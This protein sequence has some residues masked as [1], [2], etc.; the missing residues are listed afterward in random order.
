[1]IVDGTD[2]PISPYNGSEVSIFGFQNKG[3]PKA[4]KAFA[5]YSRAARTELGRTALPD[6]SQRC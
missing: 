4:D 1:M 6:A 3:T 5:S 2:D